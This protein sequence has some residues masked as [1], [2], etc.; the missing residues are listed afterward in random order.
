MERGDH[1]AQYRIQSNLVKEKTGYRC[2][3]CGTFHPFLEIHYNG[4]TIESKSISKPIGRRLKYRKA[5][6]VFCGIYDYATNKK[7]L[8]KFGTDA[9]GN[10]Y[11]ADEIPVM[12]EIREVMVSPDGKCVLY[13]FFQ[14]ILLMERETGALRYCVYS[15][16]G[17]I[18]RLIGFVN[19][20][21]IW[22]NWGD[23]AYT[24]EIAP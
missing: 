12:R 13:D 18:S 4:Q 14:E 2:S 3:S 10:G 21:Y 5:S 22:Y 9:A 11:L 7:N 15:N 6:S 8:L 23:S 19:S 20:E 16:N 24:M 1:L 17:G